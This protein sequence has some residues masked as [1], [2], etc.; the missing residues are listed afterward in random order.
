MSIL[1]LM[2]HMCADGCSADSATQRRRAA[3]SRLRDYGE[4]EAGSGP[5]PDDR[6]EEAAAPLPAALDALGASAGRPA[7]LDPEAT[8]PIAAP[9][10][11]NRVRA[12]ASWLACCM[13]RAA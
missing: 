5:P 2:P 11:R 13:P 7:F 9:V 6:D 1:L 12:A 3:D 10:H 4:G 8:R